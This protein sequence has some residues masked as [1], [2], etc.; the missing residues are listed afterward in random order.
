M[1]DWMKILVTAVL[2][3]LFSL[4]GF[5]VHSIYRDIDRIDAKFIR[6]E[7]EQRSANATIHKRIT[8]ECRQ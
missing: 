1:K 2:T 7:V 8:T 6:F 3:I 5:A 4:I